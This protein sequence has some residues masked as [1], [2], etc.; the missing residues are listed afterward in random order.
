MQACTKNYK[1][2]LDLINNT[3][4]IILF[5]LL[6]SQPFGTV[7]GFCLVWTTLRSP[8]RIYIFNYKLNYYVIFDN[9]SSKKYYILSRRL[10]KLMALKTNLFKLLRNKR[11]STF[12]YEQKRCLPSSP[13]VFDEPEP[14]RSRSRAQPGKSFSPSP[15]PWLHRRES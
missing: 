4:N 2:K 10:L 15:T 8:S 12:L 13:V 3:L 7:F 9:T 6:F 5:L 11:M 14:E 1:V